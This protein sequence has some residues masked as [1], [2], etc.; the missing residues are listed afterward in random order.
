MQG[1]AI[2]FTPKLVHDMR[3]DIF[4]ND[5]SIASGITECAA[6]TGRNFNSIFFFPTFRFQ[7]LDGII[8]IFHLIYEHHIILVYMICKQNIWLVC[9]GERYACYPDSIGMYFPKQFTSKHL[10]IVLH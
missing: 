3:T 9:L 1:I 10:C 5:K 2:N 6:W 4:I 7:L 8:E